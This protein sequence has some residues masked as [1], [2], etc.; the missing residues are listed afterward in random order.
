MHVHTYTI[1]DTYTIHEKHI[2]HFQ[3]PISTHSF[4]VPSPTFSL[5]NYLP[6]SPTTIP[7]PWTP[8]FDLIV[9]C[10]NIVIHSEPFCYFLQSH[11]QKLYNRFGGGG[12][13]KTVS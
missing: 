12:G 1:H 11:L 7:Q 5:C 13:T 10:Y 4:Y 6:S 8:S 9:F 3:P 2:Y